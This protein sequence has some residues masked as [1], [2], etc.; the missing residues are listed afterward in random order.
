MNDHQ[1]TYP[2]QYSHELVGKRV[3]VGNEIPFTVKRVINTR[4]GL[5]AVPE[6]DETQAWLVRQC[7]V[8]SDRRES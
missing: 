6:H 3:V 2:E 4:F 1:Q 8:I 5:M 7:V